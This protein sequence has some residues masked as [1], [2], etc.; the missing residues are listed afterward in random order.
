[1]QKNACL[2]HLL[3]GLDGLIPGWPRWPCRGSVCATQLTVVPA[4]DPLGDHLDQDAFA[5]L[6]PQSLLDAGGER[7]RH[8]LQDV[9]E[10]Q[11]RSGDVR[12]E[13]RESAD[14]ADVDS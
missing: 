10:T 6:L 2:L 14:T 7:D 8:L 11:R 4:A 9:V 13:L 3:E 5:G 1:M 12:A